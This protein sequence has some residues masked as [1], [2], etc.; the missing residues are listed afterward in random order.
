MR[1]QIKIL[2]LVAFAFGIGFG[3]ANVAVSGVT[4]PTI[5]VVNV[6]K[7]LHSSAQVAALKKD[8]QKKAN[9]LKAWLKNAQADVD[10]QSTP[11]TKQ[12]M[13]AKYEKELAAK[14]EA[15]NKAFSAK[16][17]EIDK[18]VT[19]TISQYAKSKG[20]SIVLA[21]SVVIYGGTDITADVAKIVK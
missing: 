2:A 10:K 4:T 5:A 14:R 17:T 8:Q 15:N 16:L 19:N 12:T 9:D 18:S 6:D 20:Y 1:K 13:R 21:K 3:C 7:V 11:Q